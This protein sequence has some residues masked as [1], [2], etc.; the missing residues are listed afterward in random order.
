[1]STQIAYISAKETD[2]WKPLTEP[3]NK[4]TDYMR[5]IKY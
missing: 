3:L 2:R 1:M 5:K 4:Y